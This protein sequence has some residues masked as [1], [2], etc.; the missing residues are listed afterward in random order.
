MRKLGTAVI[1]ATAVAGCGGVSHTKATPKPGLPANQV[2]K[3]LG[4]G[5]VTTTKSGLQCSQP[6][7]GFDK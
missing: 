4:A 6:M 2:C 7:V 5:H 1:V 3:S